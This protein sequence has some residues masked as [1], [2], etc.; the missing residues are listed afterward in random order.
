VVRVNRAAEKG[1]YLVDFTVKFITERHLIAREKAMI[2]QARSSISALAITLALWFGSGGSAAAACYAPDQQLPAQTVNDF[3]AAPGQILQDTILL[4]AAG[5]QEAG[6]SG[7]NDMIAHVR[8]LVASNPATLPLI[9]ALLATANPAQQKAIGNG[10]GQAASKICKGTDPVFAADIQNAVASSSL[11]AAISGYKVATGEDPTR[12]VA[13]GGGVSGGS[14]G[15][16]TGGVLGT[17]STG[18]SFTQ[19]TSNGTTNTPTNFLTGGA[20][21]ASGIGN[22]GSTAAASVSQ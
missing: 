12:S 18:T 21:S 19:F 17:P 1:F 10:L 16:S 15:G 6:A 9:M 20:G 4:D 14:S 8:D 5:Q 2:L 11:E 22:P 7:G 13:G 3:L